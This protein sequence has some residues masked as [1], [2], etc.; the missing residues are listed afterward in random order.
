M[1]VETAKRPSAD[2][3]YNSKAAQAN[4]IRYAYLSVLVI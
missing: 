2:T 1:K 4:I 3:D